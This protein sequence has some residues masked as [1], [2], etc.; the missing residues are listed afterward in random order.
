MTI[1]HLAPY[2][3]YHLQE[4]PRPIKQFLFTPPSHAL[5]SVSMGLTLLDVL[6]DKIWICVC[7]DFVF[8]LLLLNNVSEV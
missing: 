1:I 5:L 8:D 4:E 7:L 6:C 3:V 2:H